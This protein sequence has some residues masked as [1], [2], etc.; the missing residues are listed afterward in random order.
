[1]SVVWSRALG[2]GVGVGPTGEHTGVVAGW[3]S[4][5]IEEM[6]KKNFNDGMGWQGFRLQ[7]MF[8]AC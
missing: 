1:M 3:W 6:G 8:F 2:Y 7:K 5:N 4:G